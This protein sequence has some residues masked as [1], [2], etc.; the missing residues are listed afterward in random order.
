MKVLERRCPETDRSNRVQPD[1]DVITAL[2]NEVNMSRVLC[3]IRTDGVFTLKAETAETPED[4]EME[5]TTGGMKTQT[6]R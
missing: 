6:N 1:S 3:L 5:R 4:Q 2:S